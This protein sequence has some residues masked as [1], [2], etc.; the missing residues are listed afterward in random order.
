MDRDPHAAC[1]LVDSQ[2][3]SKGVLEV[4]TA[5]LGS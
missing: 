1:R 3:E 2:M 5:T 4:A